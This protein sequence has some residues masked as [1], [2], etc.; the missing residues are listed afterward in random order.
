MQAR[1]RSVRGRFYEAARLLDE[2]K[3]VPVG[4]W[5]YSAWPTTRVSFEKQNGWSVDDTTS[6]KINEQVVEH[7]AIASKL[8]EQLEEESVIQGRLITFLLQTGGGRILLKNIQGD[9][10]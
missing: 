2:T 8:S 7:R 1:L 9:S 3:P 4:V 5:E 6:R 10:T